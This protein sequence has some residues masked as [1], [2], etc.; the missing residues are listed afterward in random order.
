MKIKFLHQ[1]RKKRNKT[2]TRQ[3]NII[4]LNFLTLQANRNISTLAEL[5]KIRAMSPRATG[6][7]C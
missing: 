7:T 6:K 1:K 2:K 4:F 3:I 5:Y